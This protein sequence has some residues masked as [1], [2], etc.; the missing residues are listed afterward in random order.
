V[1]TVSIYALDSDVRGAN[2]RFRITQE[3]FGRIAKVTAEYNGPARARHSHEC[4]AEDV[5]CIE[6]IY[7]DTPEC[8]GL[9]ILMHVPERERL[10]DIMLLIEHRTSVLLALRAHDAERIIEHHSR[11]VFGRCGRM[12]LTAKSLAHEAWYAADVVL[13]CMGDD[14][15]SYTPRVVCKGPEVDGVARVFLLF[16]TAIDEE[17]LVT[18][19]EKKIRARHRARATAKRYFRGHGFECSIKIF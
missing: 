3:R 9:V 5:P 4:R 17:L 12:Y 8:E 19:I 2:G 6:K 15:S 1:H 13:M 16:R 14:E 7:A 10:L 11:E 18:R